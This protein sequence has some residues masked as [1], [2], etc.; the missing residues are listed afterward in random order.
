M[1][2][3]GASAST[4][5]SGAGARI[6][7]GR[8]SASARGNERIYV[9]GDLLMHIFTLHVRGY[10]CSVH[11]WIYAWISQKILELLSEGLRGIEG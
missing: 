9:L 6:A 3:W 10:A 2:W 5:A 4:G 1:R 11:A 7:A 8:A